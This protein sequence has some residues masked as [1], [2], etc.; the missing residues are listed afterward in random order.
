MSTGMA[1]QMPVPKA[2][3]TPTPPPEE[4]VND[5][6]FN[7]YTSPVDIQYDS[8]S[9]SPLKA[10]NDLPTSSTEFFSPRST[11]SGSG[12]DVSPFNF[13]PSTMAKSPVIKSVG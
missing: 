7:F 13:E 9:L 11:R 12:N 5:M 4:R 2:P 6:G 8:N 10:E 3:G 1:D